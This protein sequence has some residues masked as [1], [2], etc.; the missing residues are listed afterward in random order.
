MFADVMRDA[1]YSVRQLAKSPAFTLVATLTLALGIGATSAMFSV[2]NGVL[3][4]P[5]PFPQPDTLVLVN[6]IVPQYGLFS[7][8][9]ATFLDWRQQNSVFE[10]LAA[11]TSGSATF[12]D[13]SGPERVTNAAVS[14]DVFDLLRVQPALGRGFRADEDLPGKNGVIV[15]S[16]SMWQRRFGSD[17]GVLGRSITLSG[18]PVTVIG[19]MP[20]G[21]YFPS[22]EVEYLDA[23]RA[24]HG[25][26]QPWGALPR[27]DR[28]A[29]AWSL[30]P[31]GGR[32]DE[33]DFAAAGETV[34]GFERGRVSGG[35]GP[36]RAHRR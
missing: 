3:L 34:S 17:R 21:F 24:Q 5:L 4:R 35:E 19:V 10:R 36:A 20:P 6:E 23:H 13:A 1:R 9:P 25:Q 31:A 32:R 18:A 11:Y 33:D 27:R 22:R 14:W 16:H 28:P 26:R 30:S 2:I 12:A 29:E 15:L 7:V 8:A